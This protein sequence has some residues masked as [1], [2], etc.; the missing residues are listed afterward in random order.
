M[1]TIRWCSML[2][3]GLSLLPAVPS[4]AAS[5]SAKSAPTV[6]DAFYADPGNQIT[7]GTEILFTVEGTP[8]GKASVR[9]AG[10]P[11]VITLKEVDPGV[12]EGTYTIRTRDKVAADTTARASL[13]AR[14][15]T[16]TAEL[17]F[18]AAP[19]APPVAQPAPAPTPA[20]PPPA[21]AA[22]IDRFAV[23]PIAKIEPG[24]DLKFTLVGTPG[25]KASLAI[26]GVAKDV[27]LR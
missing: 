14:G 15:R 4:G 2:L 27:P 13:K 22:R 11:R 17:A 3:L 1:K 12:Y 8:K 26:E 18:S 20:A 25:A 24:A 19:A 16:T 23:A 7:P 6:I 5:K 10:V 9:I 21:A